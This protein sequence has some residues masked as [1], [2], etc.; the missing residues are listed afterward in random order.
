MGLLNTLQDVYKGAEK[1]GAQMGVM[2]GGGQG[3]VFGLR[4]Q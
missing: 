4:D 1:L 3:G 2:V